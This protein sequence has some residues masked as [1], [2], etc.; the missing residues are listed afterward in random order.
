MSPRV[1]SSDARRLIAEIER[2][3]RQNVKR[4]AVGQLTSTGN[5]KSAKYFPNETSCTSIKKARLTRL[6]R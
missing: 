5:A 2:P 3:L 1:P 4:P 6:L